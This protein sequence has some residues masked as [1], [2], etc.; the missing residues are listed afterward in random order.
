[1]TLATSTAWSVPG[2]SSV[3]PATEMSPHGLLI[4]PA[5]VQPASIRLLG[6]VRGRGLGHAL[7]MPLAT[8]LV[9]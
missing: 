6:A 4:A 2:G 7:G 5:R 3:M 8:I 1:M 9:D